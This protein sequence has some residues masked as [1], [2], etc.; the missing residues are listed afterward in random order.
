MPGILLKNVPPEIHSR[1]KQRAKENHRSMTQ[2]ALLILKET[3]HDEKKA[4]PPKPYK[5]KIHLTDEWLNM[6]KREGRA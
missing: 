5:G 3:L 4:R 6:A 2:E 1:L